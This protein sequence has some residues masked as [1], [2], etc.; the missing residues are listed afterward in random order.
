[1]P[2]LNDNL[3]GYW[4]LDEAAGVNRV[5]S[6]GNGRTFVE[7]GGNVAQ[8]TGKIGNAAS[9]TSDGP[10]LTQS[11]IPT[12]VG[13]F[14][15]AGWVN[16]RTGV[17][18]GGSAILTRASDFLLSWSYTPERFN[19]Q[20]EQSTG[21]FDIFA[22]V[23]GDVWH[24]VVCEYDHTGARA[25]IKVD[26]GAWLSVSVTG[27]PNLTAANLTLGSGTYDR[28]IDE[29][30]VWD[31]LL[32]DTE[33]TFLY[34]LSFGETYPFPTIATPNVPA[35]SWVVP[36]PARVGAT[37]P[38]TPLTTWVVPVPS[39][40]GVNEPNVASST[41]IVPSPDR[42]GPARPATPLATWIVPPPALVGHAISTTVR[43]GGSAESLVGGSVTEESLV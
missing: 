3:L 18:A 33:I 17:D 20:V 27:T 22:A 9:L 23:A 34:N 12:R 11:N 31:R 10:T 5:D 1:V 38:T 30:G 8:A 13:D 37:K 36:T 39:Q 14:T 7:S 35:P 28:E 16:P 43:I 25:R 2:D 41:W 26:D 32:T 29:L 21:S 19:W 4:K 42:V 6:T 24:F 15:I 40:I